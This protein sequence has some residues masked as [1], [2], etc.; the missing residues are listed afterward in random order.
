MNLHAVVQLLE[1]RGSVGEV[2]RETA[3]VHQCAQAI[4]EHILAAA[5]DGTLLN[6]GALVVTIQR[7]PARPAT[8]TVGG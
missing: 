1:P 8:E 7:E 5:H 6:G 2:A 4:L 3:P